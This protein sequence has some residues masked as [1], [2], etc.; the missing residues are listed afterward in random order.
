MRRRKRRNKNV[1]EEEEEEEEEEK[2]RKP[3]KIEFNPSPILSQETTIVLND[4]DEE[5]NSD[6]GTV[7]HSN[8]GRMLG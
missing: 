3:V 2:V 4:G 5:L 6:V 8:L 7:N 1:S